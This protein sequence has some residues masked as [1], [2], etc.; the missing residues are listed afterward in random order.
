M[1]QVTSLSHRV[2]CKVMKRATVNGMSTI[3]RRHH[4]ITENQ[5]DFFHSGKSTISNLPEAVNDWTLAVS[6]N[7]DVH[8]L[9]ESI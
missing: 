5:H 8:Y 9:R 7:Q 3:L 6:F 2:I 1:W 4:V